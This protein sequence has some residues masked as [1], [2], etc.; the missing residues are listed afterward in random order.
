VQ[1]KLSDGKTARMAVACVPFV[2]INM[3]LDCNDIPWLAKCT[4]SLPA[5][6]SVCV[7]SFNTVLAGFTLGDFVGG[8]VAGL[9]DTVIVYVVGKISGFLVEDLAP[10]LVGAIFGP[11]AVL[12]V[13]L[14]GAAFP[15]TFEMAQG[16]LELAIGWAI[17]TPL[18]YSPDP[19]KNPLHLG[20]TSKYGAKLNDAV[21]NLISPTPPP[22]K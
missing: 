8:L 17:G 1:I 9:C 5:P 10:A 14:V 22:L 19:D 3:Q 13:G 21:N 20:L 2:G 12:A 11:E 6:T 7:A 16:S 4:A 18:G 15:I